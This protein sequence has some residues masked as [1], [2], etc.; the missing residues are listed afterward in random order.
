MQNLSRRGLLRAM[1]AIGVGA[2]AACRRYLGPAPVPPVPAGWNR[3]EERWV[4]TTCGQCPAGCGINV[5]VYEGHAVKIE[6]NRDHPVNGGGLGPKGQSGLQMLYHPDRIHGPLRR[7]G[8]RGSGKWT[9][10]TWDAAI[11]QLAES[12]KEL[13]AAGEPQS[14]V[15]IDG[16]PRGMMPRMWD[17]FLQAYGSPNHVSHASA[18][19][20]ASTLAVTF[21]QGS[22]DAPAYDWRNTQYIIGFGIGLF[23]SWC[24]TIH[25]TRA[26]SVMHGRP[27]KRPKFTHVAPSFSPTAAKADEFVPINPGTYGALALGLAHVLIRDGLHDAAFLRD[28]TFGFEAWKE[29]DGRTHKGFRE[30]VAEYPPEKVAGITGIPAETIVRLAAEMAANRPAVALSDVNSTGSTNGLGTAM[31]IHAL[32]AIL[33][34]IERPGGVVTHRSLLAPWEAA[35][36]AD[37]VA[38]KGLQAVRIDG[39]GSKACPLGEGA[40]QDVPAA[41][42]SGQP[43][44]VKALILY[45][46]NPVFSK[47]EGS[48]WRE[49]LGKVPLVV[50]CSPLP[51]EST[52]WADLVLPDHTYL[53]RYEVVEPAPS[54]GR[55]VIGFRQPVV[56]PHHDTM[57]TGDVVLRLARAVGAPV[58]DAFPWSDY[59]E[60]VNDRLQATLSAANKDA[61]PAALN[62]LM[63]DVPL[64][65]GWWTGEYVFEQWSDAFKT[66]SGKFEFFSQTIASRLAAAFPDQ[67]S[68]ESHLASRGVAARGDDLCLPHWEPPVAT[69]DPKDYPFLLMPHRGINYANGG[70]RHLPWLVELPLAGLTAWSETVEVHPEDAERLELKEGD[71]AWLESPAGKRRLMVRLSVGTRPGTI[72]LPLGHGP[73]PPTLDDAGTA[74]GN[75]LLTATSDPLAGVLAVSGTRVRLRKEVA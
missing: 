48:K 31:A 61:K 41:I 17:R 28:N 7:E 15:V 22:A 35:A 62:T 8:P 16:E 72:G 6:G 67:G 25:M 26:A 1:S 12:L 30:L 60:A 68:L 73:W 20:G 51:D 3:G 38:Q 66:P 33:G 9:P 45:Q 58:A 74:G 70:V 14:L 50:S 36:P 5:R 21:M 19:D 37:A 59:H 46:S 39:R 63:A 56:K 27:G 71:Q 65:G 49:A 34:N 57:A 13:R 42:L 43:Y 54:S 47:A 69:G 2:A 23:E 55:P 75:G 53:E 32:N 18:R 10:I 40:V 11:A 4:A 52:F 44:P 29:K 24:Q 64:K